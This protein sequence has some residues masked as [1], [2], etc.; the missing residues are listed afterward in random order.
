MSQSERKKYGNIVSCWEPVC[1]VE[2]KR[3]WRHINRQTNKL[4][5]AKLYIRKKLDW[6]NHL[7]L[8]PAGKTQLMEHVTTWCKVIFICHA[9]Q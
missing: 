7:T 4:I 3:G 9:I 1:N 2:D 8:L 5:E 6:L